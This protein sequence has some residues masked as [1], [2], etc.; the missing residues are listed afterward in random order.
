MIEGVDMLFDMLEVVGVVDFKCNQVVLI[1]VCVQ[2][3]RGKMIFECMDKM[4]VNKFEGGLVVEVW[5]QILI[6]WKFVVDY[7]LVLIFGIEQVFVEELLLYNC[8]NL[9]YIDLLGL[10][11]KGVLLVYYILLFDFV[12]IKVVQDV[13]VLGKDDLLFM[14]VYEVMF[15]YFVQF[16]YVN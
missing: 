11:D 15:G 6:L 5:W 4:N 9:V 2:F 16:L 13:F 12:W 1:V 14:L 8:Q 10:F 3:V 7:D